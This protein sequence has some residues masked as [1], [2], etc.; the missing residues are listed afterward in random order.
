[1]DSKKVL[2]LIK[3]FHEDLLGKKK[4][5][6]TFYYTYHSLQYESYSKSGKSFEDALSSLFSPIRIPKE[7]IDGKFGSFYVDRFGKR[8]VYVY[9]NLA[10]EDTIND[11]SIIDEIKSDN[12]GYQEWLMISKLLV[13]PPSQVKIFLLKDKIEEILEKVK[14]YFVKMHG[15]DGERLYYALYHYAEAEALK[16]YGK[17]LKNILRNHVVNRLTLKGEEI[18]GKLGKFYISDEKE[19]GYE[20]ENLKLKVKYEISDEDFKRMRKYVENYRELIPNEKGDLED[21][22]INVF[23][24]PFVKNAKIYISLEDS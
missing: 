18:Q 13:Y 6:L 9:K 8:I 23:K 3:E 5:K 11:F 21:W 14:E 7:R 19:I 2:K 15:N 17:G 10:I 1:M 12:E 4:G 16:E 20:F 22:I 24:A